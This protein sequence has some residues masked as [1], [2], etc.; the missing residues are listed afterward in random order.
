MV[1]RFQKLKRVFWLCPTQSWNIK[2]AGGPLNYLVNQSKG[3]RTCRDDRDSS[4]QTQCNSHHRNSL[5]YV[6]KRRES[7]ATHRATRIDTKLDDSRNTPNLLLRNTVQISANIVTFPF[8]F[9]QRHSSL[10][11]SIVLLFYVPIW[12]MVHQLMTI[13]MPHTVTL[14]ATKSWL[15]NWSESICSLKWKRIRIDIDFAPEPPKT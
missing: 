13:S 2:L 1:L 10:H 3:V 14:N 4:L 6:G 15:L 12:P 7:L 8:Y 9:R 5:V 11:F